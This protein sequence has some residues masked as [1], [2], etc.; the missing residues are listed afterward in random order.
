MSF[1][2]IDRARARHHA[3]A[4]APLL[5]A[6]VAGGGVAEAAPLGQADVALALYVSQDGSTWSP[7]EA[8]ALAGFFGPHQCLCPDPLLVQ[9]QLTA[10]GQTNLGNS[11]LTASFLLGDNC[12]TLPA[13]CA[14]LGT[15]SFSATES[16]P[17]PTFDSGLVF[18]A[19]AGGAAVTCGSLTPSQTT[20]WA[21]LAQDE[22]PLPFAPALV[23]PVV[24]KTLPAPTA[25]RAEPANE[26]LR[27]SWKAPADASLVAGYQVLCLPAPEVAERA[28]Y[29]SCGLTAVS[30]S[31]VLTP[32]DASQLCSASVP[33]TTTSIRLEGLENGTLYTVG[34][35]A[36]DPSG[37]V[38]P[39]SPT[40]Q[41][42]P[43]TTLGFYERYREAGGVATG[44]ALASSTHTRGASLLLAAFCLGFL[45]FRRRLRRATGVRLVVLLLGLGAAAPARA[46]VAHFGGSDDWAANDPA[47][48]RDLAGPTWCFEIGLSLYRPAVDS[49]LDGARPF[50]DTFSSS[51]RLL[52]EAELVRY[53]SHRFGAWGI[54][55]RGGYYKVTARAFV[56]DGGNTRSGDET[57][58]RL[59][60]FAL[61]LVYRAT[62]FPGLRRVPLTPY[63]KAGLYGVFWTAS[64]TGAA[65]RTGFSPGWHVA[66]G[67]MLGLGFLNQGEPRPGAIA[68][69]LALFFEWDY[70]AIDGLGFG[71]ALHV[72]DS[73]WFAGVMFDL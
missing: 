59:I 50:A 34:V 31:P 22:T 18:Q 66:G 26:G 60:P 45:A 16:A 24:T 23:L 6:L 37:G 3:C 25:V 65:S 27:V 7:L 1:R 13:G 70:A 39:V 73:T 35:V 41:A 72:G 19:A 49:E 56:A 32:A 57:G 42:I 51:R 46:Q 54:G 38:S 36:I 28:G 55:L 21:V 64:N 68:D 53:V 29:E 40:A 58:L 69:P 15:V 4:V 44:C 12:L 14:S 8:S 52:T 30:A 48:P 43:Q 20:L 67:L 63:G 5:V 62:G 71:D 2:A 10:S 11:T 9:L 47:P 33:A 17:S 61:S